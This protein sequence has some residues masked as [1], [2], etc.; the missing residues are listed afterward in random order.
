MMLTNW[1]VG[2]KLAERRHRPDDKRAW[3]LYLTPGGRALVARLKRRVYAHDQRVAAR[4]SPRE[5]RELLRLL[6]K[7]AG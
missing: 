1:L 5:R 7:V 4:L 2:R 3:G 6:E